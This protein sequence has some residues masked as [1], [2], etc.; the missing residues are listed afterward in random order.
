MTELL[1]AEFEDDHGTTRT[2]THDEILGY[3][4]LLPGPG[5]RP[6]PA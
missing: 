1:N 2:L 6:R 3:V 5:T 4:G